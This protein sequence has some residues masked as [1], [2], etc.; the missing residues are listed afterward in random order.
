[1]RRASGL[2][3]FL[4]EE[5]GATMIE[6]GLLAALIA[7]VVAAVAFTLGGNLANMFTKVSDCVA[8]PSNPCPAPVPNP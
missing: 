4:S 7:L 3:A 1:M 5:E 8:T 6:Y 2:K